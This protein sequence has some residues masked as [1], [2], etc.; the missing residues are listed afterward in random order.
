MNMKTAMVEVARMAVKEDRVCYLYFDKTKGFTASYIYWNNWLFKAY[1]GGR[2]VLSVN[3]KARL[4][5]E[6][7]TPA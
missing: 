4:Q 6:E 7:V 5:V 2:M 1:P 3:G